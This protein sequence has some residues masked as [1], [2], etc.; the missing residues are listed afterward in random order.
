[1]VTKLRF[2]YTLKGRFDVFNLKRVNK[3]VVQ[4]D[5]SQSII[6]FKATDECFDKI[7]TLLKIAY[8]IK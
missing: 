1:M 7:S 5:K 2:Q 4:A 8:K 3:K 6:H